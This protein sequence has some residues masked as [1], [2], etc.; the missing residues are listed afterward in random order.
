VLIV[1]TVSK[2]LEEFTAYVERVS[3][4]GLLQDLIIVGKS[5]I[6]LVNVDSIAETKGSLI[7]IQKR[8]ETIAQETKI[9]SSFEILL[10]PFLIPKTTIKRL[11]SQTIK[12][13]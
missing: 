9:I 2:C 13:I 4:C 1:K 10:S 11:V 8:K 3:S 6:T 12:I 7:I 5:A